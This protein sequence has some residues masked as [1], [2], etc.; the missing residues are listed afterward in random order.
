MLNGTASLC[1]PNCAGQMTSPMNTSG[2]DEPPDI[3]VTSWDRLVPVL[4]GALWMV[5]WIFGY[6]FSNAETRFA[7]IPTWAIGLAHQVILPEVAEPPADAWLVEDEAD[8]QA[9]NTIA[10][11]KV[12]IRATL[13]RLIPFTF[14]I[15][16][17]SKTTGE[18]P[19]L[20]FSSTQHP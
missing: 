14:F 8:P 10:D 5:T 7:L 3:S 15:Y 11:P 17:P 4:V 9:A 2:V 6:A 20:P 1:A 18:A 19:P 12:A 13:A 16:L